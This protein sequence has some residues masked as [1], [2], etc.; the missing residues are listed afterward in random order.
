MRYLSCELPMGSH[1]GVVMFLCSSP[2][3]NDFPVTALGF[4][5]GVGTNSMALQGS[6]RCVV[7]LE[8]RMMSPI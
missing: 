3:P 8:G 5:S 2:F 4:S 1:S 7:F 6:S